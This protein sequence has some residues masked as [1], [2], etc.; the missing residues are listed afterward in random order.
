MR[1]MTGTEQRCCSTLPWNCGL[2]VLQRT[3]HCLQLRSHSAP[4]A[5]HLFTECI[6][7]RRESKVS[8]DLDEHRNL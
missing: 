7:V 2:A 4:L 3:D 6:Q 1:S 8:T 5:L